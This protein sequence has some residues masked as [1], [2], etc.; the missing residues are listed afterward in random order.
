M[1]EDKS[2]LEQ[3]NSKPDQKISTGVDL[4]KVWRGDTKRRLPTPEESAEAEALYRSSIN[5]GK[6]PGEGPRPGLSQEGRARSTV[7]IHAGV[8]TDSDHFEK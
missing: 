1:S 5:R 8:D 6:K 4:G 7:G 2:D 3:A